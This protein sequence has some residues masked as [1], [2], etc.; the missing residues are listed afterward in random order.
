MCTIAEDDGVVVLGDRVRSDLEPSE[1]ERL[2]D[3]RRGLVGNGA[4]S[5]RVVVGQ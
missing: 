2:L 4:R 3:D 1:L 5:A